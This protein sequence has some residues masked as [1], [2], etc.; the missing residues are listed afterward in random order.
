MEAKPGQLG[1]PHVDSKA[2]TVPQPFDLLTERRAV[3]FGQHTGSH[4]F[5]NGSKPAFEFKAQASSGRLTRGRTKKAAVWTGQLT[6]PKP[7][8]LATNSRG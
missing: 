5:G 7:F 8:I 2:P 1:V 4:A 6:Q 3:D